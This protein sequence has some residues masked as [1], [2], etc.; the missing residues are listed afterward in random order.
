MS[1]GL[2]VRYHC[3]CPDVDSVCDDGEPGLVEQSDSEPINGAND[4]RRPL[5]RSIRETEDV[6]AEIAAWSHVLPHLARQN[7]SIWPARCIFNSFSEKA[8]ETDNS[9]SG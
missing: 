6:A 7:D 1:D 5:R 9:V 2:S 3:A 8:Q 4:R